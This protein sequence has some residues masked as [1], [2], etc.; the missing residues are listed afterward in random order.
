MKGLGQVR[1]PITPVCERLLPLADLAEDHA[2]AAGVRLGRRAGP[3]MDYW[4]GGHSSG[5]IRRCGP[6]MLHLYLLST[7]YITYLSDIDQHCYIFILYEIYYIFIFIS[8]ILHLYLWMSYITSLSDI[9]YN[10]ITYLSLYE[11]CCIFIYI[12]D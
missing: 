2:R 4:H 9:D 7:N 1:F 10:T 6:G 12:I 5:R 11:L 8:I 3:S